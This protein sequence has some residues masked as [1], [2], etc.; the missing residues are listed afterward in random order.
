MMEG[1]HGL[2][3]NY[4]TP[5]LKPNKM[6]LDVPGDLVVLMAESLGI[7]TPPR[8]NARSIFMLTCPDI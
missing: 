3:S 8:T 6:S 2:P 4:K 5:G 7:T 1:R